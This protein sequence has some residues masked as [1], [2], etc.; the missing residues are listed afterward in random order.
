MEQGFVVS[1]KNGGSLPKSHSVWAN[2]PGWISFCFDAAT[3]LQKEVPKGSSIT[4]FFNNK[5]DTVEMAWQNRP[6]AKMCPDGTD[7]KGTSLVKVFGFKSHGH[8]ALPTGR[9]LAEWSVPISEEDE[10]KKHLR[11]SLGLS[12][13]DVKKEL[14]HSVEEIDTSLLGLWQPRT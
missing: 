6:F 11:K 5:N 12:L 3:E 7:K 8:F 9:Y 2:V 1:F 14:Q 13:R 4:I 10:I